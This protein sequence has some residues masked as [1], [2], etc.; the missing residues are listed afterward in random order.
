M[1]FLHLTRAFKTYFE[2][3]LSTKEALYEVLRIPQH[4]STMVSMLGT[5]S[6]V[7]GPC[8]TYAW[9]WGSTYMGHS[10]MHAW[11]YVRRIT[12]LGSTYGAPCR[13][14]RGRASGSTRPAY[15]PVGMYSGFLSS[16]VQVISHC[17]P[18]LNSKFGVQVIS[19]CIPLLNLN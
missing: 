18:L 13:R 5:G 10:T 4:S 1:Q 19:H 15:A 12:R 2:R 8:T 9:V 6:Y 3:N 7:H 11:V 16:G 17:I 14:N